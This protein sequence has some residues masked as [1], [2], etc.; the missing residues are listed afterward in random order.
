MNGWNDFGGG[1]Y[2]VKILGIGTELLAWPGI[3]YSD[4]IVLIKQKMIL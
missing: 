4:I 3:E 1:M 2:G